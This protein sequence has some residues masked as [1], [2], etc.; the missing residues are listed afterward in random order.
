M[1]MARECNLS[2]WPTPA[3]RRLPL[4]A[5]DS[6]SLTVA[7]ESDQFDI[8]DAFAV[9]FGPKRDWN[10]STDSYV[11]A[12]RALAPYPSTDGYSFEDIGN[13]SV[14]GTS[15]LE[16]DS[17]EVSDWENEGAN[18]PTRA[19]SA[20]EHRGQVPRYLDIRISEQLQPHSGAVPIRSVT[21]TTS[22]R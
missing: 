18:L 15:S 4:T 9:G 12:A 8:Q 5:S 14:S 7:T 11:D 3:P 20:T 16:S 19:V 22:R 13:D 17:Y 2:A 1:S 6:G 21:A 10:V